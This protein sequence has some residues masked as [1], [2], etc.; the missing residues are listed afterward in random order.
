MHA[1]MMFE[2]PLCGWENDM[3]IET[4]GV[5]LVMVVWYTPASPLIFSNEK[6]KTAAAVPYYSRPN[7]QNPQSA[8]GEVIGFDFEYLLALAP[9][10]Q[11][12]G[13]T[14]LQS[15]IFQGILV[16]SFATTVAEVY[17]HHSML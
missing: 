2:D 13:R 11:K 14:C 9:F 3:A 6:L 10:P 4:F 1:A 8:G 7:P 16:D 5:S 17:L 12:T 15:Y